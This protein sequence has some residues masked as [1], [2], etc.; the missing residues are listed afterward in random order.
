MLPID[1]LDETKPPGPRH[2][3]ARLSSGPLG[4]W[5]AFVLVMS[6][7]RRLPSRQ[8]HAFSRR[9]F[10]RCFYLVPDE[11][12]S[13]LIGY[14]FALATLKFPAVGIHAFVAMSNHL[15][16]V[17][18][19][20]RAS[21]ERS[22]VPRFFAYAH[23]LIAKAMN[24][25]LGRGESFWAPGAYRNTEIHD[26][27]ALLD[28]LVYALANPVAAGL[29]DTH[30]EWPGLH[31]GPERWDG[32]GIEFERPEG[33]FFGG[34]RER[35]PSSDPE[36]ARSQREE[37]R[38]RRSRELRA[39]YRA[40]REAGLSKA[41]ARQAAASRCARRKALEER[42]EARE[43]RSKLPAKAT[44]KLVT[45]ECYRDCREE[46]IERVQA[47]LRLREA[48]HRAQRE[49]EGKA[50]MGREAVLA[51]DPHS[52]A[53]STVADFS[54]WPRIACKGKEQRKHA[55][56]CLVGWRRRYREVRQKW[57]KKR[58][59]EYPPGTYQMVVM[60]GAKVMS[61]QRALREGLL[62]KPTTGPPSA[63]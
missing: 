61:E 42:L 12:T 36:V 55:L 51:V 22:Q 44:L 25:R 37:R 31:F 18:T 15:E 28:R 62:S 32:V 63:A 8:P 50:V 60:H 43:S 46:A 4:P 23:S 20:L 7:P 29:V 9:C 5:L 38:R 48:E 53:G 1:L 26:E 35:V 14:C 41:E 24:H 6:F 17:A 59:L 54:R 40:D 49:R 27:P 2:H 45:P 34:R 58:N 11:W 57:P 13:D 16:V 30:D 52:S 19:D 39:A 10:G 56:K 33:A 21:E 47:A 3:P